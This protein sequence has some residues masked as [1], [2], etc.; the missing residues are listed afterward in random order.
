MKLVRFGGR[1][2]AESPYQAAFIS[3]FGFSAKPYSSETAW[4]M[5]RSFLT[6]RA[7]VTA[8]MCIVAEH[9]ACKMGV[10]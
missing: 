3:P 6:Y 10:L 8:P 7:H 5:E 1:F 2:S 4:G 9:D